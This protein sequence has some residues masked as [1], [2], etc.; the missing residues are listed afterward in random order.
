MPERSEV[1][2]MPAPARAGARVRVLLVEDD[3]GD[4]LLV[5]ELLDEGDLDV[6]LQRVDSMSM[7]LPLLGEVDCVLLDLALPDSF[8]LEGLSK[9]LA[10]ERQAAVVVLTGLADGDLGMRAVAAG[11]QDYLVKAEVDASLLAR[12]IRYAIERRRSQVATRRL[13]EAELHRAANVRIQRGLLP[14]PLFG[15][16]DCVMATVYRP[17]GGGDVLGGDFYDAIE[18]R[19]GD[20]RVVV[21]DVSGHG[22]DEAALGV[23]L[24]IAWR[25]LV[26]AGTPDELVLPTLDDV[27]VAERQHEEVFVT[28]CDVTIARDGSTASVRTAGHPPP[29]LLEPQP[30]AVRTP[31]GP[32]LGIVP[33]LTWS[34]TEVAL[35]NPWSLLLFTDGV[36][37]GRAG[38]GVPDRLGID[39]L[40]E[41]LRADPPVREE[42]EQGLEGTLRWVEE[43]HGG[44]LADDVA[45]VVLAGPAPPAL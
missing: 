45:L 43:Q 42:W 7:A 2:E 21:G 16:G 5:Q 3:P 14:R 41:R 30:T 10:A 29:I 24:R 6:A 11:A 17:G 44:P 9:L 25:T 1:L 33:G 13:F 28:V 12:S 8:G 31:P 23:A 18:T 40:V 15:P 20:V 26:L 37:E 32:P 27:L 35:P 36:I 19:D 39:G 22:P 34:T 4:A 38:P